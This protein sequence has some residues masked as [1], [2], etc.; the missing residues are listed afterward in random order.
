MEQTL[1]YSSVAVN[2]ATPV[3]LVPRRQTGVDMIL[4][5][6]LNMLLAPEHVCAP[7]LGTPDS[8]AFARRHEHVILL[9][10]YRSSIALHNV[11]VCWWVI[12]GGEDRTDHRTELDSRAHLVHVLTYALAVCARMITSICGQCQPRRL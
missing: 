1:L 3:V 2:Y 10:N 11:Y 5:A 6:P 8:C 12:Y 4:L 7:G 9:P